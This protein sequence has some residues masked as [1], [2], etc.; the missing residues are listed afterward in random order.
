MSQG[1]YVHWLVEVEA[2]RAVGDEPAAPVRRWWTGEGDLVFD[3]KTWEGTHSDE[4]NGSLMRISSIQETTDSPDARM[5]IFINV[6]KD[7][8]RSMLARD[9]GSPKVTV[10]WVWSQDGRTWQRIPRRYIGNVSQVTA[11][12]GVLTVEVETRTG[13]V[14]KGL[15]IWWNDE[16]H[17]QRYP[18]DTGFRHLRQLQEVGA[19]IK[20]PFNYD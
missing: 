11:N 8:V 6:T 13:D 16:S 14:D 9:F 19:Q 1:S 5:Q 4:I 2:S 15:T 17:R 3:S 20:W 10:F 12:G 7:S 18:D